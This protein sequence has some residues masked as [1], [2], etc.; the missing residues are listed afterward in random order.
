[1]TQPSALMNDLFA[2]AAK[3][4]EVMDTW[5]LLMDRVA[6]DPGIVAA[7]FA[8]SSART[9]IVAADVTAA[10]AAMFQIRFAYD[11]GSPPQKAAIM[12]ML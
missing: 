7:Y 5:S 8:Q 1:M 4:V 12:K 10:L 9:D 11:G 2:Q 6:Q 3:G